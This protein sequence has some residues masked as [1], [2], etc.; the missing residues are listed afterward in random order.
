MKVFDGHINIAENGQWF[1]TGL[2]ASY[3]TIVDR[4]DE[5]AIERAALLAMPGTCTNKV[6]DNSKIDV[7]RFWRIG[8]IDFENISYSFD[9]IV[10][11]KLDGIKIHPRIQKLGLE[12]LFKS[13]VLDKVV[14][15]GNPLIICGWQQSSFIPVSSLGLHWVDLIAKRYP[16]LRI[17]VSHLGG[18]QFWDCSYFLDFF[19]NTSLESDF[20]NS[21]HLIDEKVFYGSDFPE[22]DP[23]RYLAEFMSKVSSL[24]M[25]NIENVLSCNLERFLSKDG[26]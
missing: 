14:R 19:R 8:N 26:S 11:L 12:D 9:Q 15:T 6:F 2:D 22:I 24:E 18:H 7:N 20:Y 17:S 13:N 10:D 21:L 1:D 16:E 3:E 4:L 23:G 5:I 25:V